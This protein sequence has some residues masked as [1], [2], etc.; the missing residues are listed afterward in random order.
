MK[1]PL[2]ANVNRKKRLSAFG[3]IVAGI[4]VM[5]GGGVLAFFI[6]DVKWVDGLSHPVEIVLTFGATLIAAGVGLLIG[7]KKEEVKVGT[8]ERIS[9]LSRENT[10]THES[11]I[12]YCQQ[13]TQ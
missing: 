1:E 10:K 6:A 5:V 12:L 8:A 3:L 13:I 7:K 11:A 9:L 2:N 4:A